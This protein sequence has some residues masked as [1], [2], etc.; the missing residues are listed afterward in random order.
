MEK[1]VAA[2]RKGVFTA[3]VLSNQQ[4][5][6][7]YYR[8]NLKLDTT[9]SRFFET[10]VPGQFLEIDLSSFSLPPEQQ[11]PAVLRDSTRQILLRRPFSFSDVAVTPSQVGPCVKLE[12]L[13]CVLGPGTLRMVTLKKG[14]TLSLLG[15][16]G[17]GFSIPKTLK[18][19]ILVAGGMGAPPL[20][21]LAGYLTHHYPLVETIC[22]VGARSCEDLP[23]T[24]KIGN[25]TGLVLEEFETLGVTSKVAT[26]DGSAGFRGYVTDCTRRWLEQTPVCAEETALFACGPEPMLAGVARLAE[27]FGLPCQVSMERMMACGI[28][29]CQSC[30]VETHKEKSAETEYKLC[31][32]DG[33]V[34]DSRN[35]IF[36][37]RR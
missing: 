25:L 16:L 5:R 20:L 22:F 32:K 4:I 14:D 21:H 19:A 17:N 31:C 35:V 1:G 24:T 23:F 26:D 12:L 27:D 8:L 28:G 9:G 34:F 6:Q 7:C 13:Y 37:V 2:K 30:A 3:E 18:Q 29:L 33:P 15:P 36:Q 10:V 11:I